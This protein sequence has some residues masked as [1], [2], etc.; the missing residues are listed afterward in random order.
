MSSALEIVRRRYSC[1]RYLD[2][3]LAEADRQAVER[4]LDSLTEG[5]F[6][7]PCRFTLLAATPG[8][9]DALKGLGTYGFVR[10]AKGFIV[11]AVRPRRKDMED[12][13]YC[14]E[15]AV[16][17]ATDLGLGTCW[18]GGT[19]TKSSFASRLGREDD[20]ILPAIVALGY[21]AEGSEG[22]WIRRSARGAQRKPYERLF[23]DRTY[24]KP[25][26][27]SSMG[28]FTQ[29]LESVRWAPSASN[30]QPW[31]VVRVDD[32]WHFYLERTS[33]PNKGLV[34]SIIKLADLQ[35][36]DMGIAMCHFE[37]VAREAGLDGHW[38]IEA[39][40]SATPVATWEYVASWTS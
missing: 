2:R 7:N 12:Y 16:L 8:D 22:H 9:S 34:H 6:G 24:E 29:A 23:F 33:A 19:F 35:R 18:L 4:L 20:E 10:G 38:S 27:P 13:G 11:G 32:A 14:L 36:V 31:R 26:D 30:K 5:P 25:L 1:R 28:G 3:P 37:L 17:K 39:P 21:A 15:Q 40:V